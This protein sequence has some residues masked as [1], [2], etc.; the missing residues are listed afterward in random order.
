MRIIVGLG[1][2]GE[3]YRETRHNVGFR[4]VD[5]FA[6]RAGLT[7]N[8]RRFH[9]RAADGKV[10]GRQVLVLKPRTFVNESGR[11]VAAAVLGC[12]VGLDH[13]LVV[14]DDFNLSVGRI[15]IK[16]RGSAGGH[17]GLASIIEALGTEEFPRLRLG[18]G[19]TGR[20]CDRDFVLSRFASEERTAVAAAVERAA[21][22]IT[23]WLR[24]DMT[25]CMERINRRDGAA[26]PTEEEPA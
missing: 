11:A 24:E 9:S 15:K 8:R 1:N 26:G 7:F 14:L 5:L 25:R 17:R 2:P 6:A 13:L 19:V 4:V 18:I 21:D 22:A 23:A 12:R 3:E 10:A 20:R 16:P